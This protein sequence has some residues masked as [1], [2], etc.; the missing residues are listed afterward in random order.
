[1]VIVTSTILATY[2]L[3]L[4]QISTSNNPL[5]IQLLLLLRLLLLKPG[6]GKIFNVPICQ[7]RLCVET[8]PPDNHDDQRRGDGHSPVQPHL[9]GHL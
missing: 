6:F 2:A 8:Q 4:T 7:R 9:T 1:M 3:T 5:L